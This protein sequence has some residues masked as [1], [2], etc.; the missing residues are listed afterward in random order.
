MVNRMA[1]II[2]VGCGYTGRRVSRSLAAEGHEVIATSRDTRNLVDLPVTPLRFALGNKADAQNLHAFVRSDS[3]ILLST[4]VVDA[5][6][7]DVISRARR[8]VFLS[9]TGVY[10]AQREVNEF[11][12]PAP[13]TQRE[14]A[15]AHSEIAL[16]GSA[17]ILRPA[18]IYGPHRGIHASMA[19]GKYRLAADGS[20]YVSRI[21]VD[22]LATHS[23]AALFSDAAGAWPVAD[24]EPCTSREIAEF[25]AHLLGIPVPPSAALEEL[26]ET[27]QTDRR[28]DGSAIRRLLGL[29]L[30]YPSYRSG[31]PACVAAEAAERAF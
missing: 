9:T 15:R 28:V 11:S 29:K 20:N 3:R 18:A 14:L 17:M 31:I 12:Q 10:G 2:I 24:E 26:S 30:K 23:G 7:A 5:H 19:A 6:L 8:I 1:R 27:R 21:H 25:C 22:D 4:P 16:N 13:R